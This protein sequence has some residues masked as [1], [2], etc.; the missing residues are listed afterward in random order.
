MLL[1]LDWFLD[2]FLLRIQERAKS[3]ICNLSP[4]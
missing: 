2:I 1:A 4:R 3:R